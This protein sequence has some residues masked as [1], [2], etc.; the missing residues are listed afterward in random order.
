MTQIVPFNN[1]ALQWQEIAEPV[2]AELAELFANSAYS[3]G[4]YV[5]AFEREIATWLGTPNAIACASG[6]AALHLAMVAAGI[7]PG[8]EVLVPAHTFIATIWGVLYVGATP[9]LCEVEDATGNI[10]LDDAT[11]RITARTRAIIPVH[12]YGQ[13]ADLAGV[14]ALAEAH[15][16][17]IIEDN[18]QAIGARYDN[19]MLGTH[20]FMGCFSFYP[21]KNLGAAGEAGMVVTADDGFAERLRDLRNHAQSERYLHAELGFNYRMDGVQGIVLRHKLHRLDEWNTRRRRLAAGYAAALAGLPL[22]LPEVRHQDHVWHLYVV[23]TPKRDALRRYLQERGIETGLHY[24]IP[25]HRQPCLAHLATDPAGFPIAEAWA[26]QGL[27][28]PLFHGMTDAQLDRTVAAIRGFF[29]G[30]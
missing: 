5:D 10:D 1:L 21:G 26:S 11:R 14:R 7:G 23:R 16:L 15:G 30:R 8:D 2:Q 27:S 28:L 6:T 9:V 29:A 3:G 17:K 22:R 4:R 25:N 24:P 20:G 13:P 19:R 18:A 12:L